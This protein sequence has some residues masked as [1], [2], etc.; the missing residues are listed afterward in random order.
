MSGKVKRRNNKKKRSPKKKKNGISILK[1]SLLAFGFLG[2]IVFLIYLLPSAPP[3]PQKPHPFEDF[4]I[5]P[6]PTKP[7]QKKS[8]LTK[9]QKEPVRTASI[10][11]KPIKPPSRPR[12]AIIIDDMGNEKKI[13]EAFLSLEYPI[14]F[15]F[16]PHGSFTK[17]LS[18]QAKKMGRDVLVHLPLE[19]V[20]GSIYPGPGTLLTAMSLDEMVAVLE[21]DLNRVPG[22]IG[23][24]NHMGS[25]FTADKKSMEIV[26]AEVKRRNMFFVDSRTTKN[27]IAFKVA[28]SM[29]IPS[30]E[31]NVFLDHDPRIP[32]IKK[33]I[34]RLQDLARENGYALAIAHPNK[35]TWKVLYEELPKLAK[36]VDMVPVQKIVE[37]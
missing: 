11:V 36:E 18:R 8:P 25:K 28:Q 3:P 17:K 26:L 13:N 1:W 5:T 7:K 2:A 4:K 34:H 20:D 24:N 16:L 10:P 35:T 23:V 19:P 29:G 12:V 15:S 21:D 14:S 9:K 22:A 31:R 30:T 27:T 33:E 6:P 37:K 32:A